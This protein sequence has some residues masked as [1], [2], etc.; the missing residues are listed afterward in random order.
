MQRQ[1]PGGGGGHGG[2]PADGCTRWPR[3]VAVLLLCCSPQPP[4][5]LAHSLAALPPPLAP[6]CSPVVRV[7][8]EPKVASDLPKLVE[9]EPLT[10]LSVHAVLGGL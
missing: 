4:P 2:N 8:V 7:A 5:A 9:G 10:S 6:L 3:S 1:Q